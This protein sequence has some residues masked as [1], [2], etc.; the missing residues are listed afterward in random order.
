MQ[1][2]ADE[3]NDDNNSQVYYYEYESLDEDFN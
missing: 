2:F 3:D 1:N